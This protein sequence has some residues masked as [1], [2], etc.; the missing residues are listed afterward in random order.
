MSRR[1]AKSPRGTK[2][3]QELVDTA[4]AV[5]VEKG[6][7]ATSV[8][9]ITSRL[10]LTHGA[11]YRYFDSKREILDEVIDDGLQRF[12]SAVEAEEVPEVIPSAEAFLEAY[13]EN[14]TRVFDLVG[15]E[16][17]LARLIMLEATSV[18]IELTERLLGL[19]DLMS[20]LTTPVLEQAVRDGVLRE[21]LNTQVLADAMAGIMLPGLVMAFRGQLDEEARET[22]VETLVEVIATGIAD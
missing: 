9:D 15:E 2:R 12:M 13:R 16:P 19:L 21:D 3:R 1:A 11:F 22:Q 18:D 17:G 10:G 20:A 8:G 7:A 5:F 4:F 6:Y 14:A